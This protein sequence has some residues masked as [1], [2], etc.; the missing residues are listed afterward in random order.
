MRERAR[1]KRPLSWTKPHPIENSRTP[2]FLTFVAE[3]DQRY[4]YIDGMRSPWALQGHPPA[5][6]KRLTISVDT[7]LTSS[8]GEV[9]PAPGQWTVAK[10]RQRV[11]DIVVLASTR[12]RKVREYQALSSIQEYVLVDSRK[13]WVA[14]H[15]RGAEELFV[16]DTEHIS[17]V[18]EIT[19]IETVSISTRCMLESVHSLLRQLQGNSRATSARSL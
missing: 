14:V 3:Q 11:P 17:G 8:P 13:R 2:M 4:E 7:H 1:R 10:R 15:R 19:S 9:L 16:V 18:V 12:R 5:I 6:N